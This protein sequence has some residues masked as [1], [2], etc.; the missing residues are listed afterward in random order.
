[1]TYDTTTCDHIVALG[2]VINGTNAAVLGLGAGAP[3][4]A[5]ASNLR[6]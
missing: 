3:Q 5:I 4:T 6:F 1:M 2:N